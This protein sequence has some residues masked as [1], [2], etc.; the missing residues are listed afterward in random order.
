M[1]LFL[2]LVFTLFTTFVHASV[3]IATVQK[4][5]GAVKIKKEA[6]IKKESALEGLEVLVGDML[7]SSKESSAVL[8]LSDGSSL[9]LDANSILYF[10]S[11]NELEQKEGKIFYKITPRDASAALKIQTPFAIIGIKGTTFIVDVNQSSSVSLK[12]GLIGIQSV[13]EEFEFYKMNLKKEYD[14]Y[15]TKQQSDF[16]KFKDEQKPVEAEMVTEFD[17][18]ASNK[19]SFNQNRVDEDSLSEEDAKGFE[20]FEEMLEEN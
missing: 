3:A 2:L 10:K 19:V 4:I 11:Q 9:V 8:V 13:K 18:H 12:E 7:I 17:L 5:K 15:V 14:D 16:E 6:S 20:Y 1:K